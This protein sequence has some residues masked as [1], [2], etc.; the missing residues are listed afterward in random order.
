MQCPTRHTALLDFLNGEPAAAH[1]QVRCYP[2]SAV[3][4][5]SV[6]LYVN[7]S[8]WVHSTATPPLKNPASHFLADEVVCRLVTRSWAIARDEARF[9]LNVS[10]LCPCLNV[11]I[12]S[13][14]GTME[15]APSWTCTLLKVLYVAERK[16]GE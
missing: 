4:M 1:F 9:Q 16:Y 8:L 6:W 12:W 13:L 15:A 3:S 14:M 7:H 10:E 5:P 11:R 2:L